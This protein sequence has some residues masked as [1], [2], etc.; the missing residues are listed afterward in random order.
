[1]S[2]NHPATYQTAGVDTEQADMALK[3]LVQQVRQTWPTG[4][5]FGAVQLDMGYFANVINL[6]TI[7]L[8]IAADGVG[9]K[10]TRSVLIVWR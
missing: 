6:G 4:G 1:M 7:G 3:R 2:S 8:A 9:S 5:G 10:A